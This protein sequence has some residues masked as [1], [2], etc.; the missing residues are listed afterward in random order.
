MRSFNS[1]NKCTDNKLSLY[2]ITLT[3]VGAILKDDPAS[4]S[5][6]V[7]HWIHRKMTSGFS[8]TENMHKST[9]LP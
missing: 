6:K 9:P 2:S 1:Y 7:F 5:V 3:K 8:T 4:T